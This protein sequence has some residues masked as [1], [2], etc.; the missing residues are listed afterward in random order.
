MLVRSDPQIVRQVLKRLLYIERDPTVGDP[1]LGD[2]I[3]FRKLTVGDRRWR[4]VWRVLTD[5]N[6]ELVVEIAEVWGVGARADSAIYAEMT[7]RVATLPKN[8]Q[9][10]ALADVIESIGRTAMG[11]RIDEQQH[12][13]P[14]PEWL[15]SRLVYTAGYSRREVESL[16]GEA[17]MELWERFITSD[18]AREG[19]ENPPN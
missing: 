8:P 3:G 10:I 2:L 4:I 6:G 11:F 18:N 5:S 7:R 1:L 9:T 13:D 12:R 15:L 17:A 16:D 14:L 19:D